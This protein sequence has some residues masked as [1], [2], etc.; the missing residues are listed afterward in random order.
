MI[1]KPILKALD[2]NK[3]FPGVQALKEVSLD[4]YQGQ[5]LA[6]C[7]ENGA[8]K[9]T[10]MHILAGAQKADSGQLFFNDKFI[11]IK[12]Q[13]HANE[14][15]ISIVYQER[16]L[17]EGL[18]VAENIF[19]AR[20]PVNLF[21]VI[22]KK[23]LY[24]ATKKLLDSL[25]I[26]INPKTKVS[27]LSPALQQMVEIVKALS[28]NP[29]VLILDEPTATITE[30][31]VEA[32]FALIKKLKSN[33]VAVLYI[34]HRLSEIFAIADRVVV[35]KDGN[36]TGSANIKDVD[37]KWLIKR[38]V[39]RDVYFECKKRDIKNDVVFECSGLSYKTKLKNINFYLNKGEIL[40]FAGL[41][42]AGR[43]EIMKTIFGAIRKSNGCVLVDGEKVDIRSCMDAVKNG[44]GY[45]PEDRK[46]QGL[47]LEMPVSDNIISASL[48]HFQK[49]LLMD[50]KKAA[51]VADEYIGKLSIVC[52]ASGQKVK[53][54][55]GGNQQKVSLAKWLLLNP[56][57]LIV[58]EP[59]RGVDV[60]AKAEIYNILRQLT[61][62]GTSVIVV[63]SELPEIL[64][65]SDRIYTVWNGSISGEFDI[66]NANEENLLR[67]AAGV[68]N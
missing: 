57:I 21:G 56:K 50:D 24:E 43:T 58:D 63:S 6:I 68:N 15:G 1:E 3:H 46:S 2:I 27:S 31:E 4:V 12:N 59:T 42:G 26:H 22:K 55:S 13:K 66:C 38:M 48:G 49:F 7:G 19:S 14:I 54:L 64:A 34:S 20:Q 52:S 67:A 5:V 45:L 8:G 41:V 61:N 11:Q 60:G 62:N 40:G 35:L 39:G 25:D 10:L 47:F 23:T 51:A 33:G 32:L 30:K 44:I 53:T 28:L 18:N 16:S 36:K 37:E 65:I 9:S 17:V 29:K